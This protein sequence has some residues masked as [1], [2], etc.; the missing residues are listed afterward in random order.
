[1]TMTTM[2]D[3][4]FDLERDGGDGPL[5]M[6]PPSPFWWRKNGSYHSFPPAG[7]PNPSFNIP[8][9]LGL[10]PDTNCCGNI[11]LIN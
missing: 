8:S 11:D 10:A 1:M 4:S 2:N 5:L 6:T 7:P 3:D 9:P